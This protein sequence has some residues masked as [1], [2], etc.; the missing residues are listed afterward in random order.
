[1][2]DLTAPPFCVTV[3]IC[4]ACALWM[5]VGV[6]T[7]AHDLARDHPK[8]HGEQGMP[9]R[10]PLEGRVSACTITFDIL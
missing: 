3:R 6:S 2:L 5:S 10:P 1:M 8:E 4:Q 9:V 7:R